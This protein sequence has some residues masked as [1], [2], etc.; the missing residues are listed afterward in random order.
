MQQTALFKKK[1]KRK[2]IVGLLQC[3]FN[4]CVCVCVQCMFN[5]QPQMNTRHTVITHVYPVCTLTLC[6]CVCVLHVLHRPFHTRRTGELYILTISSKTLK[7]ILSN[8]PWES[9]LNIFFKKLDPF[10]SY[11]LMSI[12]LIFRLN[13]TISLCNQPL[14]LCIVLNVEACSTKVV[15][16]SVDNTW[17]EIKT[18]G[19]KNKYFDIDISANYYTRFNLG[20][21]NKK[22]F[23]KSSLR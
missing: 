1:L 14:Y 9:S 12:F 18:L 20:L 16:K 10:F 23:Y 15:G 8:K 13:C 11:Y 17:C 22:K 5:V 6:V 21:V 2:K 4:V 3:M 7:N 19:N